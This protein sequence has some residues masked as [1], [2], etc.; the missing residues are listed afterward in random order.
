MKKL[1]FLLP[2]LFF[3]GACT[4]AE[5]G[6]LDRSILSKKVFDTVKS[7]DTEKFRMLIPDRESY[8]RYF[9]LKQ[10]EPSTFDSVYA[11]MRDTL[12]VNFQQFIDSYDQW[13][14]AVYANTQETQE[15][16][17]NIIEAL[18]TTKFKVGDEVRKYSFTANKLNGRWY[19]T[20]DFACVK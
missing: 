19:V 20:G 11:A 2:V 3:L 9:H 18:I 16:S 12:L 8:E 13:D 15:K 7:G 17:D 5:K 10:V 4:S 1:L 14:L 6:S